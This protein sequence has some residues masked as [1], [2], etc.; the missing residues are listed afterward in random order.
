M[1]SPQTTETGAPGR[2]GRFRAAS[3]ELGGGAVS[4]VLALVALAHLALS[5]RSEI[6]FYNGDS[7]LMPLVE[8]A[9]REGQPFEWAMS[10]VLF[11]VPEIPVYSTIATFAP[12]VHTALLINAIVVVVSLY[13]IL[14]GLIG[15]LAPGLKRASKIAVALGPVA[16]LMLCTLLEHTDNRGTLELVS[17]FLTTTYYYGTTLA[18]VGATTLTIAAVSGSTQRRRRAALAGLALVAALATFSNPLFAVWALAPGLVALAIASRR[19]LLAWR[20]TGAVGAVFLAASIAGYLARIPLSSYISIEIG[21]YF[22]VYRMIM[23]IRY[24]I[25]VYFGTAASWQGA[26]EMGLLSVAVTGTLVVAIIALVRHWPTK[27]ALGLV[28]AASSIVVTVIVAVVLGTTAT[29]YLMPLFFAPVVATVIVAGYAIERIPQITGLRL[30][31]PATRILVPLVSTGLVAAATLGVVSTRMLETAPSTQ[32]YAPATCLARWIGSE[33]LTGAGRFWTMRALKTYGGPSIKILQ[34]D[35]HYKASLWL[36]NMAEY[37][38]QDISYLVVDAQSD[39]ATSPAK[40]LGKPRAT[41]TCGQYSILDYKNTRGETILTQGV[42][43]NAEAKKA[44]RGL[45]R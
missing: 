27:T 41:I 40:T 34:V 15:V 6:F 4:V 31:K 10:S 23:S 26:I 44:A 14:R 2:L 28:M 36:D 9:A 21:H 11:F 43:E 16:V 5:A 1:D 45:P 8:R 18:L 35:N 20:T 25:D 37:T 39:F 32:T 22:R 13:A 3:A 24:Y 12:E 7:V 29:R 30:T 33:D 38:G 19:R 17:L 42:D